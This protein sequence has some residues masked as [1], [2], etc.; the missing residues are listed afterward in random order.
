MTQ[1]CELPWMDGEI[2]RFYFCSLASYFEIRVWSSV[3]S[4][5][6]RRVFFPK[7]Q[8]DKFF[9]V[10]RRLLDIV[11]GGKDKL[12][13]FT[14][15]FFCARNEWWMSEQRVHYLS[16]FLA[17]Q[18]ML[19]RAV[20]SRLLLSIPKIGTV[21][22]FKWTSWLICSTFYI[23]EHLWFVWCQQWSYRTKHNLRSVFS[24]GVQDV[25][26]CACVADVYVSPILYTRSAWNHFS[27]VITGNGCS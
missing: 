22:N 12:C 3:L 18:V 13:N 15:I 6:S 2:F 27:S 9:I 25:E 10:H 1:Y 8:Q 19:P 24:R 17:S 21:N 5:Y 26:S 7:V 23:A 14:L 16:S 20:P 4:F 11:S